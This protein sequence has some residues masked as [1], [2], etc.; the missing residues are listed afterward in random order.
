LLYGYAIFLTRSR[1]GMLGLLAGLGVCTWA[2]YGLQR[3]LLAGAVALPLVLL[4][5]GGRQTTMSAEEG[6]G[7]T[8]IQLWSDWMA[9]FRGSP[10]FGQGIVLPKEGEPAKKRMPGE[11]FKHAAHNSYLQTYADIGF[12]AGCLFLGAYGLALLSVYRTGQGRHRIVEA[13]QE[14]QRPYVLAAVASYAVGMLTLSLSFV[15]PTYLMLALAVSYTGVTQCRPPQPPLRLDE[16]FLG[17]CFLL[18]VGYLAVMYVF[19]RLFVNR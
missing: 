10:L 5:F 2:R 8:R 16:Q 1:G 18:G 17:R 13:G 14:H 9:E 11:E 4:V 6:T 3:S 19:I 7:Q 15:V 12:P